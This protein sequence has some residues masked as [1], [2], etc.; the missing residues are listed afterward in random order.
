MF[1]KGCNLPKNI[2]SKLV[3]VSINWSMTPTQKDVL[4]LCEPYGSKC[5]DSQGLFVCLFVCFNL[6]DVFSQWHSALEEFLIYSAC[7][8]ALFYCFVDT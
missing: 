8:S 3:L 2:F 7:I 1:A 5:S 6:F 4:L